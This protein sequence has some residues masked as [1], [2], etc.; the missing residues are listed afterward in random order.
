MNILNQ[1]QRYSVATF[2]LISLSL[3]SFSAKAWGYGYRDGHRNYYKYKYRHHYGY[4]HGFYRNH[5]SVGHVVHSLPRG[6]VSFSFSGNPYYFHAGTYYRPYKR[7]YRV[8]RSPYYYGHD[9]HDY[10][11]DD[12]DE[13]EYGYESDENSSRVKQSFAY[14][15]RGQ[16]IEKIKRDKYECYVWASE[17]TDYDPARVTQVN[18][19]GKETDYQRAR[20]ACLEARGYSVK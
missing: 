1:W 13:A 7:Y 18:Y 16:S 4:R 17:Q 2:L 6:Y 12:Y 8:V 15:L 9:Y 5:Y 14:P 3:V 19:S 11:D 10:S 20:S